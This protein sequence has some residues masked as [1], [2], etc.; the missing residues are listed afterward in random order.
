MPATAFSGDARTIGNPGTGFRARGKYVV[1]MEPGLEQVDIFALADGRSI[2]SCSF[3]QSDDRVSIMLFDDVVCGPVQA[4]DVAAFDLATPGVQRWRV[5]GTNNVTQIFKPAP[6]LLAVADQAGG[7]SLID[8]LS[9][10][11]RWHAQVESCAEGILDGAVQGDVNV[12]SCGLQ[13]RSGTG[14]RASIDRQRWGLAAL[15]MTDGSIVWQ[16]GEFSRPR[17]PLR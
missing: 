13:K 9:G 7:L 11:V 17:L 3:T 15:R 14:A 4:H 16:Q 5:S 2:G 8:P 6:D 10:K 1:A 12:R